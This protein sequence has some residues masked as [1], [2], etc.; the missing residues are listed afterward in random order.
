MQSGTGLGVRTPTRR[1]RPVVIAGLRGT[2]DNTT[3]KANGCCGLGRRGTKGRASANRRDRGPRPAG[4]DRGQAW[5]CGHRRTDDD[6][7][8]FTDIATATGSKYETERI[9]WPVVLHAHFDGSSLLL[10][11]PQIRRWAAM[12]GTARIRAGRSHPSIPV[13]P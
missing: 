3:G 6:G 1:W 13:I 10:S 7:D 8:W 4:P 5:K 12:S 2:N 11:L 9:G